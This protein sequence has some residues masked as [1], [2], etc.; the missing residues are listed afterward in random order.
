MWQSRRWRHL[1][2][3]ID[4][5][6]RDSA[7]AEA[8]SND[9]GL[10]EALLKMPQRPGLPTRR[11]RE[12]SAEVELLSALVDR[13]AELIQAVAA[14]KGAKPKQVR[15]MPRPVTAIQRLR[16]RARKAKHNSLV[17]R[18][19]PGRGDETSDKR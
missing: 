16:A 18:L 12:W 3:I 8:L 4:Q 9:E 13:T 10:A 7:F 14:T 17:A 11:M 15:W 2:N 5:L 19:L 6:P 1:L